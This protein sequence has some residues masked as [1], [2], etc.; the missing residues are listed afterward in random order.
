MLGGL[1]TLQGS[2]P[3]VGTQNS[4]YKSFLYVICLK[5]LVIS[6]VEAL[7]PGECELVSGG[8]GSPGPGDGSNIIETKPREDG[9]DWREDRRA[10]LVLGLQLTGYLTTH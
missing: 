2:G 6:I 7:D 8:G 10:W 5:I 3:G 1:E 9:G 4:G